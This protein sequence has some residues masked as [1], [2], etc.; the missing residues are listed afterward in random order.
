MG[1][2]QIVYKKYAY[3]YDFFLILFNG[4]PLKI[5]NGESAIKEST[6]C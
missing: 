6:L 5:R 4:G 2:S 3:Y 1:L